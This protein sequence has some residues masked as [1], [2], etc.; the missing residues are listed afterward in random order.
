MSV[1]WKWANNWADLK[2]ISIKSLAMSNTKVASSRIQE[3]GDWLIKIYVMTSIVVAASV[4][5]KER[6][7]K[8][9]IKVV[10]K[11]YFNKSLFFYSLE[12]YS[13]D[14]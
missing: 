4:I 6:R 5:E 2:N 1:S 10:E 14:I 8:L 7:M 9:L 11:H 13:I 3:W 12:S